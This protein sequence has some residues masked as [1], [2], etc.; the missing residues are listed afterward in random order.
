MRGRVRKP[1]PEVPESCVAPGCTEP[2]SMASP[3]CAWHWREVPT[4]EVTIY[5]EAIAASMTCA[6]VQKARRVARN[7]VGIVLR[8]VKT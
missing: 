8:G 2:V 3:C 6:D 4:N 5:R 7:R 1:A